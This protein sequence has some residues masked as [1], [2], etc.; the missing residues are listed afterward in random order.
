MDLRLRG[1]AKQALTAVVEEALSEED[2]A[3]LQTERGVKSAPVVGKMRDR[4][5]ALARMLAEGHSEGSCA[6]ALRYDISRV[7]VLKSD[8]AFQELVRHYRTLVNDEFVGLQQ[9]LASLGVDAADILQERLEETPDEVS[10]P[11]LMQLLTLTADRTGHGPTSKTEVNVK[12]GI[13]DK[14]ARARERSSLARDITPKG[15]AN[16]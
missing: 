4:H 12:V 3:S 2:I 15:E 8:P 1:R 16:E 7:S 6:I 13:A 10:T 5:H 11:Q 14:L 9:K